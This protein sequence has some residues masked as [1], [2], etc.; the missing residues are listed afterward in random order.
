MGNY[1]FF[2]TVELSF[3]AI[4]VKM[5]FKGSTEEVLKD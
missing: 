3:L 4:L 5:P 2:A 1:S